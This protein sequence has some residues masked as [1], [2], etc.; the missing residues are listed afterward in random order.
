[1]IAYTER[2]VPGHGDGGRYRKSEVHCMAT[3]TVGLFVGVHSSIVT[4][5]CN[6]AGLLSDSSL[7]SLWSGGLLGSFG[8]Q[9]AAVH[10][11]RLG[12]TLVPVLAGGATELLAGARRPCPKV[13]NQHEPNFFLTWNH[14]SVKRCVWKELVLQS[15][16]QPLL[17]TS[18]QNGYS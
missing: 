7:L 17:K 2:T 12:M 6:P 18:V 16:V 14:T 4:P 10:R 3:F 13:N 8:R 11:C 9:R 15:T 1:M 5:T